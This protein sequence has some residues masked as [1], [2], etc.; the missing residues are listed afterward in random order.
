MRPA[1]GSAEEAFAGKHQKIKEALKP[2]RSD[3]RKVGEL[4][5]EPQQKV[6]ALLFR[7]VAYG[8]HQVSGKPFPRY[9]IYIEGKVRL[10][11]K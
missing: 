4:L 5:A 3:L 10:T 6:T 8:L 2:V 9:Q 7:L 11:P 1:S